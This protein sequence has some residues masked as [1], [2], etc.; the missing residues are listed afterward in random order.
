MFLDYAEL[1]NPSY[2]NYILQFKNTNILY[3]KCGYGETEGHYEVIQTKQRTFIASQTPYFLSASLA[4]TPSAR[5]TLNQIESKNICENQIFP[6][7]SIIIPIYGS[8]YYTKR[9]LRNILDIEDEIKNYN[10]NIFI[11][12]DHHNND[13]DDQHYSIIKDLKIDN[14][15]IY[16]QQTN[17][18]FVKNS[19]FL[20]DKSATNG[21]CI[22]W[23]SDVIIPSNAI[24][25]LIAPLLAENKIALATPYAY[26]GANLEVP[27][28]QFAHWSDMDKLL[29]ALNPTYPDAETNVGYLLAID[30]RKYIAPYLFD[31]F[32]DN[33][34][35]DDSDLYY[36]IVNLGLRGILVDNLCVFH[37]HGASFTMTGRR[38]EFQSK[39]RR[40]FMRRW[41]NV[42][43][44][45][46]KNKTNIINAQNNKI[47]TLTHIGLFSQFNSVNAVFILPTSDTRIGGV[48]AVFD[49]C[50]SL[51]EIGTYSCIL[52]L[53]NASLTENKIKSIDY[54]DNNIRDFILENCNVIVATSHDTVD[55]VKYL[56]KNYNKKICYFIQGPEYSFS[57]GV[58]L[59]SVV[60]NYS[61]FDE[62]WTVSTYIKEIVENW[63][64]SPIYVI[65]Y[66]PPE[67]RY[68]NMRLPRE[69]KSIAFQFNARHDKGADYIAAVI[70]ALRRLGYKFYS[71]GDDNI[72]GSRMNFCYH[73][74]FLS[75]AD[76]INIFN[77]VEFYLDGSHFEG[78]GLLLIESSRC[79]AIPIYR[80]N[81]GSA[82]MLRDGRAGIEVGDYASISEIPNLLDKFR[83]R[84]D[85]ENQRQECLNALDNCS[86]E[87]STAILKER[88]YA[89]RGQ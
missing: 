64:E 43:E 52:S 86:V 31:T 57:G 72:K 26:G 73:L 11:S 4:P 16:R 7:I 21:I 3:S 63:T 54:Y 70:V 15:Y 88:I 89:L 6:D 53:N 22:L 83:K 20:Y 67:Y 5:F 78:L 42:L 75:Y 69:E 74:G 27:E 36:R 68:Y 1:S 10:V 9:I 76:K 55:I 28:S 18:G 12:I 2:S 19:N 30:R 87:Q 37:E 60:M 40:A 41:Q 49:I 56:G 51:C 13:L 81:G 80:H 17:M 39:N 35:G 33:G 29:S 38:E 46:I 62:I 79:G 45:R 59:S 14:I 48:K 23:T 8:L 50:D 77:K 84:D 85:W 82:K 66:G 24:Y 25:R 44:S 47:K 58:H 61:G 71:F 65:P 34:Y 32:I